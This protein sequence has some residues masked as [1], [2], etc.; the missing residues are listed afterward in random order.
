MSIG[1]VAAH[2]DYNCVRNVTF[3]NITFHHPLKSI[4]IKT[5]PGTTESMEP[6]SGGEITNILYENIKI[7]NPV[8]WNIYIGPQQQKQ[9][10]G[11]GPGCMLYPLNKDCET[12]PL[13]TI[14]NVT[15]RNIESHGGLLPAGILR[16][17]ETHPCTD[18]VFDNVKSHSI[19]RYL[20]FSYITENMQGTAVNSKP[21]PG[22]DGDTSLPSSPDMLE[23]AITMLTEYVITTWVGI[24]TNKEA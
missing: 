2:E 11:R 18:I 16:C 10:D 20:G 14:A 6:G 15:L 1:S 13:V 24:F 22:F 3:S 4:Y 9:P 17:N 21:N 19:W 23:Q 7:Y 12:Q 8:W 5:N